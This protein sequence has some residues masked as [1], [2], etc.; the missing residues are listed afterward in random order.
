MHV[1]VVGASGNVGTAVLAAL[2]NEPVVTQL[3]GIA[4]R[5]PRTEGASTVEFPHDAA[6]WVRLDLAARDPRPGHGPTVTDRLADVLAGADT[7]IHVARTPRADVGSRVRRDTDLL[8]AQRVFDAAAQ[9]HVRHVVAAS[10]TGAYS[11][12]DDD[13]PRTESW[14][15]RGG[16]E[17]ASAPWARI[18][19]TTGAAAAADRPM[20]TT[21]RVERLLV[22]L[23]RNSDTIVTSMRTPIVLHRRVAGQL[24]RDVVGS[25]PSRPIRK[26]GTVPTVLWPDGLRIQV[27]HADDLGEA[28][29]KVVIQRQPGAFNL[30]AADVLSG[31]DFADV[32]SNGQMRTITDTQARQALGAASRLGVAP[33]DPRWLATLFDS[34]VLDTTLA[35]ELLRWAPEHDARSTLREAV[36]GIRDGAGAQTPPLLPA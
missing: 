12:S 24:V 26:D 16:D 34:P 3:V 9:A 2:A 31:Q 14:P 1:V 32:V 7:V 25:L 33:V 8:V 28:Y 19:T 35:R 13:S 18:N 4:R 23:S 22:A 10:C 6:Q 21:A 11:P 5:V 17:T 15:V 27:I 30:A 20:T 36:E 29:R